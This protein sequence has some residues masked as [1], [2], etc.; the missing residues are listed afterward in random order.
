MEGHR[1]FDLV[2]WETADL[3][4]NGYLQIEQKLRSHLNGSVFI[5]GK[6]EYF[7][8]PQSQI[9]LSVDAHRV[10]HLHQNPG[11]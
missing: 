6:N 11:Y 2:R 1:F 10:Q 7:P 4:I 8:I 9:D 3:E 5:K